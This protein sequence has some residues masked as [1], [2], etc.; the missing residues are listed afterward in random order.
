[1]QLI[2]AHFERRVNI[3]VSSNEN[4]VYLMGV[5]EKEEM[6]LH[7]IKAFATWWLDK[8]MAPLVRRLCRRR[9]GGVIGAASSRHCRCSWGCFRCR[10]RDDRC[11]TGPPRE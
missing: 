3:L 7:D 1:M 8:R 4:R 11:G 9:E 10:W 2:S 6:A 5:E